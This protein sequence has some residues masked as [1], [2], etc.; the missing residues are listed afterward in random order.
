MTVTKK[1]ADC[2]KEAMLVGGSR[3]TTKRLCLCRFTCILFALSH[4]LEE[5]LGLLFVGEGESCKTSLDL[6]AVEEDSVLVV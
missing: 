1:A 3:S 5:L 4:L 2:S 6:E